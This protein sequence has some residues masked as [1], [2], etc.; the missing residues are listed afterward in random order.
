V[1][2]SVV[3]LGT[4]PLHYQWKM[5]VVGNGDIPNAANSTYTIPAVQLSDAG[6]YFVTVT[7]DMTMALSKLVTLTVTP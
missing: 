7:N 4:G 1:T 2:F 6:Q 3:A 5:N